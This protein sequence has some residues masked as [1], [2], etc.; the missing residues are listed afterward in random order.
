MAGKV[1]KSFLPSM[2]DFNLSPVKGLVQDDA[3]D[4]YAEGRAARDV[5]YEDWRRLYGRAFAESFGQ[6]FF[7]GLANPA[8]RICK[9]IVTTSMAGTVDSIF[10]LLA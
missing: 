3:A 2:T 8:C 9:D 1:V 5:E 6:V 10:N 7:R 4:D